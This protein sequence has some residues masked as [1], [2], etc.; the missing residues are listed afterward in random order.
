MRD[1]SH[2]ELLAELLDIP[3]NVFAGLPLREIM[4]A[5]RAVQGIEEKDVE[6]IN[7]LKELS[8]RWFSD[9]NQLRKINGPED[10]ARHLIAKIK[11]DNREHFMMIALNTQHRLIGTSIISVGGLAQAIVH[12]REVFRAAMWYSASCII[13][14]H[15]HPSGRPAPSKED[16]R[17]T[18]RLIQCGKIMEIPVLDHVILGNN[19]FYSYKENKVKRIR[20]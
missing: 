14:A 5:P 19:V 7:I 8:R 3:E 12:P 9:Q 11:G 16:I 2:G 4:T 13:V 15:N 10:V 20:Y 18:K 1:K 6:K 17:V